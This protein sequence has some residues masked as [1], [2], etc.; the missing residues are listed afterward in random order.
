MTLNIIYMFF[1]CNFLVYLKGHIISHH[2]Y[3]KRFLEL[4]LFQIIKTTNDDIITT[5]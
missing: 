2:S 4:K 1:E 3:L 5:K